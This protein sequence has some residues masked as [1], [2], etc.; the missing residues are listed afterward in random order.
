MMVDILP[1]PICTYMFY[2]CYY[3]LLK[4][5]CLTCNSLLLFS[6]RNHWI[7]FLVCHQNVFSKCNHK[8]LT[9]TFINN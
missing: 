1:V 3:Y 8:I 6:K 5:P 2:D 7:G 9:I 4:N